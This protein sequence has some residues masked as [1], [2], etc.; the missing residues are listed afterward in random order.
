M[1]L[2]PYTQ[3]RKAAADKLI[4]LN[5]AIKRATLALEDF[6]SQGTTRSLEAELGTEEQNAKSIER[7]L[8]RARASQDAAEKSLNDFTATQPEVVQK[9][10]YWKYVL[11]GGI[12]AGLI[13][14]GLG[15]VAGT[16]IL[17]DLG[18]AAAIGG[19]AGGVAGGYGGVLGAQAANKSAALRAKEA[20][21]VRREE[22]LKA[23]VREQ[24]ATSELEHDLAVSLS[25]I[26]SLRS[27]IADAEARHT[28]QSR[29]GL[30]DDLTKANA[31]RDA[32]YLSDYKP[33]FDRWT[34]VDTKIHPH[35]AE[36]ARLEDE[37]S[38]TEKLL[39]VAREFEAA[40]ANATNSL[41]RARVHRS[42]GARFESL[43]KG[44]NPSSP[45]KV[46]GKLFAV[47]NRQV[48]E[49]DKEIALVGR[50]VRVH[51]LKINRVI[52]DGNN[53]CNVSLPQAMRAK[54]T[55]S[56]VGLGPVISA[57]NALLEQ[58]FE[59][60]VL[61]DPGIGKPLLKSGQMPKGAD[62]ESWIKAKISSAVSVCIIRNSAADN[63]VI[64][65][66]E[67]PRSAAITKDGYT[68]FRTE[69]N[70]HAAIREER[71]FPYWVTK[72]PDH[73]AG[74]VEIAAFNIK[75]PWQA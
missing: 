41:E 47:L 15:A 55:S 69:R 23:F 70:R 74:I 6:D 58:G 43:I 68:E 19:A 51:V 27:G 33:T 50:L 61:F 67:H 14:S 11:S 54:K 30:E 73:N 37:I 71:V 52:I 24:R 29:A 34:Q 66:A 2:N 38:E 57:S 22:L 35:L 64:T 7:D 65:E 26:S 13:A 63:P 75:V 18:I 3:E 16:A 8:V 60:V 46:Y 53:L 59:V 45:E 48:R 36:I 17:A 56:F 12:A 20:W 28:A 72:D 44:A 31:E 39:F 25:H 5:Q 40:L 10:S 49:R 4:A 21:D 62:V 32:F 1:E 42:C 9:A